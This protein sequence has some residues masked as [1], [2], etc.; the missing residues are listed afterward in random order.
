MIEIPES[1]NLSRQLNK[2]LKGKVPVKVTAWQSPHKLAFIYGDPKTY[3]KL[4]RGKLFSQARGFGSWV[5]MVFGDSVL[6]VSED[7]GLLYTKDKSKLPKKHQMLL[8]FDDGSHLCAYV[9]MYG[10]VVGAKV[11]TYDNKYYLVAQEKPPVLSG[12]FSQKYYLSLMQDDKHQNL[13]L[14]AFLATEQRIPGLGNGVLQDILFLSGLHPKEKVKNTDSKQQKILY[15]TIVSTLRE[16]TDKGG[17]DTESDLYGN[18][19]G[20]RTKMS[21]NTVNGPCENCRSKVTKASYM[22]G[23][24]YFC[25]R[26]QPLD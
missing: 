2:A 17:R 12:E 10:A 8:E 23:S 18:K 6:A 4:L 22:G 7:T 25:P 14:K 15:K 5:E 26:C 1:L 3:G 16:M 9:K 11:G 21:K 20:Y 13:S 24:I 19:G